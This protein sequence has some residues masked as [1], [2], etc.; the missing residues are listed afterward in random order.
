VGQFK[1]IEKMYYNY[2][3]TDGWVMLM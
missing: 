3:E 1:F 2:I